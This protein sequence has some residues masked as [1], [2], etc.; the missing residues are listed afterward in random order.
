M[1]WVRDPFVLRALEPAKLSADGNTKRQ[2]TEPEALI[3]R[4]GLSL[5]VSPTGVPHYHKEGD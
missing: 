5:V 3:N 2:K 4:Y 1:D